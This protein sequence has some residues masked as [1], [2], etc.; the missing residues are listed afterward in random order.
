MRTGVRRHYQEE[1]EES[2]FISM[3][4]M[5]VSFLFIVIL[6]LAFFAA[7]Y[8]DEGKVAESIHNAVVKQRDALLDENKQLRQTNSLL[9]NEVAELTQEIENLNKVIEELQARIRK[10]EEQQTDELEIYQAQ[11][12]AVRKDLLE[13][14]QQTINERFTDVDAQISDEGDALRLQGE[15]LFEKGQSIIKPGKTQLVKMIASRLDEELP[16]FTFG[17]NAAWSSACNESGVV[18]E[19]VQI[20]G[21]TDSDGPDM[22][23]LAL[24]TARANETFRTMWEAQPDLLNH[25]NVRDQPVLSVA[26]YG[27]MRP[28][29]DEVDEVAKSQN[30][31]I[32]L[33]IIMYSPATPAEIQD[34]R[35]RFA[36]RKN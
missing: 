19:A 25:E 15:G 2:A 30:R 17:E 33:R 31:R 13:R 23:N 16:C 3:T 14:L 10:L 20:E 27:E 21:H 4:D 26:G 18:I 36:L 28:I 8:G 7:H 1:E 11:A 32:D 34:I 35:E 29:I 6:L 24:S 5:T 12:A 9:L 22:N